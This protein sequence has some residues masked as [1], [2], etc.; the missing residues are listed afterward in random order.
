MNAIFRS[1][2]HFDDIDARH[3]ARQVRLAQLN[4]RR[5]KPALPNENWRDELESLHRLHLEEG[6]FIESERAAVAH[7]VAE[8]PSDADAF[9]AWFEGLRDTGPGQNDRLFPWLAEHADVEAMRWFLTQE[10]GGEAGFDDLVAL[11]QMRMPT[12]V[13]LE[14]AANYWDEMG[15]GHEKGMHGPMLSRAAEELDVICTNENTLWE[16]LALANVMA[17]LAAN[18]RY[19]YQSAG[20]LG[21]IEMTAPGR[22]SLVNAGLKRLNVSPTGRQ[23]FQLHAG[24]DIRHSEA[25]NREVIRPLVES[26]PE[27]AKAIGEGALLRLRCGARCFERYRRELGVA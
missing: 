19:A 24:L 13:K 15:R 22:V 7:L 16:S 4:A 11:T 25:W 21:V 3:H 1:K 9:M 6:E 12:R 14:M 27:T 5:F 20:A 26:Q 2:P 10:V 8:I 23:Y 17:G 18:R